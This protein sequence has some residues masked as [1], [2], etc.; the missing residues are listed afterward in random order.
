MKTGLTI[1]ELASE[2][3]R[4]ISAK[5]DFTGPTTMMT[6]TAAHEDGTVKFE[7]RDMGTYD[8]LDHA[9]RQIGEHVGIPARYYDR[10][11]HEAPRLLADNVNHWLRTQ[12]QQKLIRTLDGRVR[13]F[14]SDRYRP[15]DHAEL[16]GAVLPALDASGAT[17]R[18]AQ[19]TDTKLYIKAVV[20]RNT[21]VIPRPTGPNGTR[22][23]PGYGHDVEIQPGIII[24][25]SEVGAGAVSIQPAYHELACLNMAT[26][27]EKALRKTHLGRRL[28]GDG[29][30]IDRYMSDRTVQLADEMLWSQV[31]DMADAALSGEM[32]DDIVA[33]LTAAREQVFSGEK[34]T[35]VIK[36]VSTSRGL[37]ETEQRAMMAHLI[38]RGEL[39]QYGVQAAITRASQDVEDYDR[40]SDLER[41]GGE[42]VALDPRDWRG[43]IGA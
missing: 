26:W 40:A 2:V 7:L 9:H 20:E 4:Q 43:L 37:N 8:V 33:Q 41:I 22:L 28:G 34:V 38:E 14:L 12:E 15:M 24:T 11:R 42:I 25:N 6:M 17:I 23:G 36:N 30:R 13:A 18:S 3:Q 5:Q 35:E 39:S 31:K 21:V 27:A 32:F 19:I 16:I 29:D 10:M 1:Q